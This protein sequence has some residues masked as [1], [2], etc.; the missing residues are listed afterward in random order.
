MTCAVEWST[1]SRKSQMKLTEPPGPV[2]LSR[3][4]TR[5]GFE[6]HDSNSGVI[7]DLGYL[8]TEDRHA[9]EVT[10]RIPGSV[11]KAIDAGDLFGGQ[12]GDR[13]DFFR[14]DTVVPGIQTEI[15]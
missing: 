11:D 2:P 7:W 5:T 15:H 8:F 6:A 9:M 12:F 1:L 10:R 4:R 3:R 14:L 13:R